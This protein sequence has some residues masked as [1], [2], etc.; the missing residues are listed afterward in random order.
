MH[1]WDSFGAGVAFFFQ[2]YYNSREEISKKDL[3]KALGGCIIW[4]GHTDVEE[5]RLN[6]YQ[7][8]TRREMSARLGW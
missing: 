3:T 2:L 7:T 6:G 8:Q 1:I 5:I 4:V